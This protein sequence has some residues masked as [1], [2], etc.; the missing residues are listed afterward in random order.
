MEAFGRD[1]LTNIIKLSKIPKD[2][3]YRRYTYLKSDCYCLS[4]AVGGKTTQNVVE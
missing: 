1:Y 2:L 4:L 3:D